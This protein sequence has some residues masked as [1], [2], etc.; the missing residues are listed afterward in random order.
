MEEYLQFE[1]DQ[2]ADL[3]IIFAGDNLVDQ[4]LSWS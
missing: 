4:T 2:H 1:V 3:I